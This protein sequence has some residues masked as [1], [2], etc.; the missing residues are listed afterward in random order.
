MQMI[1]KGIII[2]ERVPQGLKPGFVAKL[3]RAKPKG[4]AYLEAT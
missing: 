1:I 4:L 2:E 3:E